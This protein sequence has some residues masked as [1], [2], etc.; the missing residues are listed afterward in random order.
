M[1]ELEDMKMKEY[2]L[3]ELSEF[4]GKNGKTYV[5]YD[6]QVYDV[7][8]S[9]LWEDGTHQGLHESGKDLTEDMD[10]APHGPEVFKDYPVVGTLK[11]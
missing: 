10:E 3:E 2:T 4:N 1:K 11:K 8:N 6:G 7:S 5:V 9:Y